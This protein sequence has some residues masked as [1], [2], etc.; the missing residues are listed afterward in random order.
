MT[1][2]VLFWLPLLG[3]GGH[4]AGGEGGPSPT[5]AHSPC[6]QPQR[7]PSPGEPSRASHFAAQPKRAS[8]TGSVSL[9]VVKLHTRYGIDVDSEPTYPLSVVVSVPQ[10]ISNQLS[11]YG[12][13]GDVVVGPRGWTG[14][15]LVAANGNRSIE[16]SPK[17]SSRDRGARV[18]VFS[19]STGEGSAILGAAPYSPWIQ[20]HWR[21][22]GFDVEPPALKGGIRLVS[23]TPRLT[24]YSL[25]NTPEG[26]E[27]RGVIFSDA[28]D[29]IQDRMW[30]FTQMEVV[31]S[32]GQRHLARGIL[33]VFITQ[34]GLLKK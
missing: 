7:S 16:L 4:Y 30:A 3:P 15:G 34:R 23:L 17:N 25:P 28:Q 2:V 5:T 26:L 33:D 27:V 11:A 6:L 22:L 1:V 32:R 9:P 14:Q 10:S 21:W 18:S 12:A 13:A 29:R 19:A 24:S 20:S 31:L 8:D